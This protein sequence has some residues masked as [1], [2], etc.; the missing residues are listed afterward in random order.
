MGVKNE[1]HT[2]KRGFWLVC[3]PSFF[4]QHFLCSTP[5]VLII[6]ANQ[7][8]GASPGLFSLNRG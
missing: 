7:P 5:F 2:S 6:V 3:S 4:T 8:Q 1:R